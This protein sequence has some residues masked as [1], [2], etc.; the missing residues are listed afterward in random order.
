MRDLTSIYSPA[1]LSRDS[2]QSMVADLE[3]RADRAFTRWTTTRAELSMRQ[4]RAG[5]WSHVTEGLEKEWLRVEREIQ[6]IR[7]GGGIR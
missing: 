1:D 7:G 2:S 3:L 4:G 5:D 6:V